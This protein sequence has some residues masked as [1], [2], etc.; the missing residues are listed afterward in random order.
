MWDHVCSS[1]VCVVVTELTLTDACVVRRR[2]AQF[3]TSTTTLKPYFTMLRSWE[4]SRHFGLH[5]TYPAKIINL[6][7]NTHVRAR[8][9]LL[10]RSWSSLNSLT[11]VMG[12]QDASPRILA[13]YRFSS[14]YRTPINY[15]TRRVHAGVDDRQRLRLQYHSGL[16]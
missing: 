8:Y 5:I 4:T 7:H 15:S 14:V 1:H 2:A 6:P 3:L 12:Q 11:Y 16:R 13:G 10:I 9:Q